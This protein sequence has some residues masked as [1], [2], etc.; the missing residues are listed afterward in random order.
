MNKG[1]SL[2]TMNRFEM[3]ID[4]EL[5]HLYSSPNLYKA[6]IEEE[7]LEHTKRKVNVDCLMCRG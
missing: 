3:W 6:I 1:R 5:D 7:G 2:T 4:D